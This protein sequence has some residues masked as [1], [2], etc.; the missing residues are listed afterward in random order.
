MI[1]E[2]AKSLVSKGFKVIF[3]DT[4]KRPVCPWGK[5]RKQQT[6]KDIEEI[7]SKYEYKVHG[8]AL[9]CVDGVECIDIDQ[10]YSVDGQ[11]MSEFLATVSDA[12]GED[13]FLD[14]TITITKSGGAHLIYRTNIIEGNQKL[15]QRST[16][17][18]EQGTR[19]V[20]I[21][22]RGEGGY[23]IIPPT[24]GYKF[25]NVGEV[26]CPMIA[27]SVRK[28]IIDI[29]KS[30]DEVDTHHNAKTK[31]PIPTT[32]VSSG[33]S[34]IDTFNESHTPYE[35][36]T[37]A[38]WQ[39]SHTRGDN[40]YLVRPGKHKRDGH[41]ASF[42]EKLG[43]LYVFSSSTMFDPDRGYNAFQVY[44]Y[45]NHNGDYKAAARDLYRQGYGERKQPTKQVAK[46]TAT[47]I[48]MGQGE[49][50]EAA[51]DENKMERLYREKRV[52]LSKKPKFVDYCL[53]YRCPAGEVYNIA[54]PGDIV[55]VC[56]L[57]K[58]RKSSL[59][60]SF[61]ASS[62]GGQRQLGFL[63]D[64]QGRDIIFLDTEQTY[65]E[66]W[67][68]HK[69]ILRQGGVRSEPDNYYAWT[70]GDEI[71][72]DMLAFLDYVIEK[73]KN[74]GMLCLDGIVDLCE[75]YMDSTSSIEL[76][77]YIR[78]KASKY[79][80]LLVTVLHNARS[81][82]EARGHLGTELLNKAKATIYVEKDPEL[83]HST[84]TFKYLREKSPPSFDFKHEDGT[85]N[86]ILC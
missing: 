52:F 35:L 69:R 4:E 76:V 27:D 37:N 19:R 24:Q 13:N 41:S 31:Q 46:N 5:Y 45:L 56:G 77:T 59:L 67:R 44:S 30:F 57:Q 11:L 80:L 12:I 72:T 79:N 68:M 36:L 54:A 29:A 22:T 25:D 75:D 66:H 38:G 84:V 20:L 17:Q 78:R 14:L 83:D 43:I 3:T 47:T 60:S 71:R 82:R 15:A 16:V 7:Y 58:S 51:V 55:V 86:L 34:T 8:M 48:L 18:G 61:V 39:F 65:A 2:K 63:Q 85:G 21:E 1:L 6:T 70:I 49:T 64:P 40:H 73:H 53:T 42:N 9:L 23:F 33:K 50:K 26:F 74:I 81:T 32:V 62:L 10:K 28:K